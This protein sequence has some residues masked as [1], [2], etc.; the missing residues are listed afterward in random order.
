MGIGTEL[1]GVCRKITVSA[2]TFNIKRDIGDYRYHIVIKDEELDVKPIKFYK[3]LITKFVIFHN[4]EDC[5]KII[6]I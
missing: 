1:T 3:N 5:S 2:T 6:D 4:E